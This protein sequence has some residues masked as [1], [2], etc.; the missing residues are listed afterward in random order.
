MHRGLQDLRLI[1][2]ER[3]KFFGMTIHGLKARQ[4]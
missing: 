3:K 1:Q 4:G 2:E